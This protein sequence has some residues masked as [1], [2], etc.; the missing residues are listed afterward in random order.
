MVSTQ[1]DGML[2]RHE[3]YRSPWNFIS[4]CYKNFHNCVRFKVGNKGRDRFWEE[5]FLNHFSILCRLFTLHNSTISA[6]RTN[7]QDS[8]NTLSGWNFCF[9][10]LNER[11]L[12]QFLEL[13][14]CL[15]S[16]NIS[17]S[18]EDHRVWLPIV[19]RGF[20]CKSSFE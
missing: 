17:S 12:E 13:A 11:E 20:S 14:Y 2:K 19:K 1:I 6:L 18:L 3:G 9:N 7:L 15:D 5:A 8:S 16:A 4:S 10:N